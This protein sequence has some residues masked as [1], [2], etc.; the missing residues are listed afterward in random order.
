MME[1]NSASV[2]IFQYMST[3]AQ[4]YC[5]L[6]LSQ[7]IPDNIYDAQWNEAIKNASPHSWQYMPTAGKPPLIK[8]LLHAVYADAFSDAIIVSG[9]TEA[10]LSALYAWAD[11]GYREM[12][13]A[14]PF[15]S[16]YP[17]LATL[18]HLTFVPVA[19][20]QDNER[21]VIDWE[22]MRQRVSAK[23]ILLIN[24]PHNPSGTVFTAHDWE[25]LWQLQDASGC[26]ILFD[27]VYRH[28][29]FTTLP[30]PD[31]LLAQRKVLVAGSVSKSLAATGARIGWLAGAAQPLARAHLAHKHMSNCQPDLLQ[32]AALTL[33]QRI[34]AAA[35]Q[36]ATQHY[37]Q[38]ALRL[39]DALLSA[40]FSLIRP[41]GGHFIMARHPGLPGHNS[42]EQAVFLT[43]RL[44]IA[45]LPL[46]DFFSRRTT[47]WLRFSF[48]VND[49]AV[50]SAC[51]RLL[52]S[53]L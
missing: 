19:M 20:Q 27:D 1:E 29:N 23:S 8:Y 32:H 15:Y 45:P 43:Q 9:C 36:Q 5:A 3:L 16:Y 40:G 42:L 24:S 13:V 6:N 34:D 22:A 12:V 41:D 28:F 35:L 33:M 14:E 10:L 4:Q 46:N 50:D 48:A 37:H 11:E 30:P 38:R 2:G 21:L 7:G 52:S 17:G 18:A 47:G 25:A 39:G 44:G 49:R 31:R 53:S 51:Q 26:A